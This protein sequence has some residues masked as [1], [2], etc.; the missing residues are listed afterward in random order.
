[1]SALAEL[2]MARGCPVSGSDMVESEVTRCLAAAGADVHTGHSAGNL[3]EV[4]LLVYSRAVPGDNVELEAARSRGIP[5]RSRGEVVAGLAGA[6]RGVAVAGSHGKTSTAAMLASVLVA[7]GL[8]PTV[9]IGGSVLELGGGSRSGASDVVVAEADESDGSHLLMRPLHAIITS[10]DTDHLDHYGGLEGLRRAFSQFI[11][12]VRGS[13]L[14]CADDPAT[15]EVVSGAAAVPGARLGYGLGEGAD[16]RALSVE[17]ASGG[18]SFTV[19][20]DGRELG[21]VRLGSLG[22]HSVLNALAAT[23]AAL[24]LGVAF[25]DCARALSGYRG[26][27]RRFERRGSSGGVLVIDDYAHHPAEIR[28]AL[29]AARLL[30]AGRVIVVFQPHRYSRTER[31]GREFGGAFD[32]AD[33]VIIT[34]IY[35]AGERVR[36][37][38]SGSMIADAVR[39]AGHAASEFV[40]ALEEAARLLA[41]EVKEGDLVMTVGAGD[42]WRVGDQVLALLKEK[43]TAGG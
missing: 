30:G 11:G 12:Q 14:W 28:R 40:P 20:R 15:R 31:I 34:E 27:R 37:G 39:S 10:I 9:I 22:T 4:D 29:S 16:L 5:C 2:A 33:R 19:A 1:M 35:P 17:L 42:V 13:L 23:G 6:G 36:A 25:D 3:G 18:S 43:D 32:E 21:R 24:E 26:V 7:C 41:E 8:D 38:V